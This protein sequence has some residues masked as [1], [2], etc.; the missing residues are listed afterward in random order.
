M[1]TRMIAQ[2]QLPVSLWNHSSTQN[3]GAAMM[4]SQP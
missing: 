3:S 1:V 4:V 2:P